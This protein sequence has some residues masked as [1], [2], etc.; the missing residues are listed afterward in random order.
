MRIISGK[1][2]GKTLKTL[3]GLDTRPT[4]SRVKESVF[5]IIQFNIQDS[6]VLDLFSGSGQMGIEC[7]SRG[8][9]SV[10][11]VD[12]NSNAVQIIKNNLD[13]CDAKAS[14]YKT[15]YISFTKSTKNKYDI[16][17]LDPP[18]GS[19]MI[20]NS[21]SLINS[22]KLLNN[23]GIIVCETSANDIICLDNTNFCIQKV[24]K[25]GTINITLIKEN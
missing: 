12:Q 8:A 13:I 3:E 22:F 10:D 11:F 16:I 18:Y 14:V 23:C 25:Y 1:Y 17:L 4:T 15:D 2:R 24:Y 20:N 9:L 19:D 6:S 21:L 7:L 5:N